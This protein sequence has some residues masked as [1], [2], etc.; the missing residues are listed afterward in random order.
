MGGELGPQVAPSLVR[1]AHVG[2][3]DGHD[4]VSQPDRRHDQAFL[5]QVGRPGGQARGL[6]TA[7]VRVVRARHRIAELRA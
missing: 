1:V 3:E 4:L 5:V 6:G 2:E 7:D